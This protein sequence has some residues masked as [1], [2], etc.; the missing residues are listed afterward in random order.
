MT[1]TVIV[2]PK[3]A[4]KLIV[5]GKA[6]VGSA[7]AGWK[8]SS[9]TVDVASF[10]KILGGQSTYDKTLKATVVMVGKGKSAATGVYAKN[11]KA[12]I[13]NGKVLASPSYTVKGNTYASAEEIVR[14]I[15]G[16]YSWNDVTQTFEVTFGSVPTT[17]TAAP[18]GDP[19]VGMHH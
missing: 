13:V 8:G 5:N 7:N 4:V 18:T 9:L 14:A 2:V 3:T 12:V 17:L 10:A 16:S 6:I 1:G 19:H 15:G 11:G